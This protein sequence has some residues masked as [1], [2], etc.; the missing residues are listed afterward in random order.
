MKQ[1]TKEE[2]PKIF[3]EY[4][5]V[6]TIENLCKWIFIHQKEIAVKIGEKSFYLSELPTRVLLAQVF[7]FIQKGVV[8]FTTPM[9]DFVFSKVIDE[10]DPR[11]VL[12]LKPRILSF[13]ST[14][15]EEAIINAVGE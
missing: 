14:I 7:N 6:D 2:L 10:S 5:E 8:P 13:E 3:T 11:F 15:K 4:Y 1:S 12:G 9:I